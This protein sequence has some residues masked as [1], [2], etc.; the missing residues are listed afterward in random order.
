MLTDR[1]KS[2]LVQHFRDAM[3]N[4]PSKNNELR[5]A[6]SVFSDGTQ[7]PATVRGRMEM[8]IHTGDIFKDVEDY[9]KSNPGVTF[10]DCLDVIDASNGADFAL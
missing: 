4:N 2:Q 3:E 6:V 9:L 1:Q 5:G 8:R 7:I 10:Q